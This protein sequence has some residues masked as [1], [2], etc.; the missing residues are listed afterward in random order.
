VAID[1]PSRK[2]V[3]RITVGSAPKRNITVTM[4]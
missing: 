2:E 3:A 1:V 4:R